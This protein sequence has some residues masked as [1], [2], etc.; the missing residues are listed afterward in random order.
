[1]DRLQLGGAARVMAAVATAVAALSAAVP[2]AYADD[3]PLAAL[4]AAVP[5]AYADDPPVAAVATDIVQQATDATDQLAATTASLPSPGAATEQYQPEESQYH[6]EDGQYHEPEPTPLP[7]APPAPQA[8]VQAPVNI[9]VAVRVLS[10][11][12]D[13]AVTQQ[14]AVAPSIAGA[15]PA[16]STAGTSSTVA[17]TINVNVSVNSN[18]FLNFPKDQSWYQPGVGQYHDSAES[19][20]ASVGGISPELPPASTETQQMGETETPGRTVVWRHVSGKPGRDTTESGRGKRDATGHP[21]GLGRGHP[22]NGP[23]VVAASPAA[24]WESTAVR[25]SRPTPRGDERAPAT[26]SRPT[27]APLPQTPSPSP[28]A[29]GA[30]AAGGG[31]FSTFMNTLAVLVAALGLATLHSARRLGLP[32][33]RLQ[34]A[35]GPRPEK[36]G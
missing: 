1:M 36:P 4:S 28:Q 3:P 34:E 11:G 5:A 6:D 19:D 14:T 31:A 26:A 8:P 32:S 29:L 12:D 25:P 10:P 20:A 27:P 16:D 24:A 18:V 7:D 23:V 9:N 21:R 33:R 13:G 30:G 2:A 17:V 35:D 22:A 15:Q